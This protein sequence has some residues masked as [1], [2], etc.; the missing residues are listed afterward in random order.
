MSFMIVIATAHR[1][2]DPGSGCC[3]WIVNV[4]I[5]IWRWHWRWVLASLEAGQDSSMNGGRGVA[6]CNWNMGDTLER[7]P[8]SAAVYAGVS[9]CMIQLW[10]PCDWKDAVARYCLCS[11]WIR[12]RLGSGPRL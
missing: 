5:W 9:P 3:R 6:S 4:N 8:G 10:R 12:V 11:L 1:Q 2:V 7:V